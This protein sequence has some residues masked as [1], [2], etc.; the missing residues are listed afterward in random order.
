MTRGRHRVNAR[1]LAN[2]LADSFL[3]TP[4]ALAAS[5]PRTNATNDRPRGHHLNGDRL[6]FGWMSAAAQNGV[7]PA[8]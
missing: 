1:F 8:E 4:F 3:A 5:Q 7:V 6:C 2:L